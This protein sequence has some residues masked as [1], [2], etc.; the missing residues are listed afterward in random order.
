MT[1]YGTPFRQRLIHP[2]RLRA[3]WDFLTSVEPDMGCP[4]PD[5]HLCG[6]DPNADP[7]REVKLAD[8][9]RY[10]GRSWRGLPDCRHSYTN[11]AGVR[12]RPDA[13]TENHS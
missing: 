8:A 3:A 1:D 9:R 7:L 6:I 2:N 11:S 5:D 4:E 12:T 10:L 13:L